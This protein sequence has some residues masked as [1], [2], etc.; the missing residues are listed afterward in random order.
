MS[1][2]LSE[3]ARSIYEAV[4]GLS[5]EDLRGLMRLLVPLAEERERFRA[6]QETRGDQT[7]NV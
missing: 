6:Q 3:R 4:T 2:G 1:R 5:D 7:F